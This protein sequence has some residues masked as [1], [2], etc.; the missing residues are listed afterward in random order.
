MRRGYRVGVA[1]AIWKCLRDHN[2][3]QSRSRSSYYRAKKSRMEKTWPFRT[4]IIIAERLRST[5]RTLPAAFAQAPLLGLAARAAA[6]LPVSHANISLDFK[7]KK[8]LEGLGYPDEVRNYVWLGAFRPDELPSLLGRHVDEA[9]LFAPVAAV[10]REAP[11]ESHLERV[12]YQDVVLYLAH[13]ILVKVD[14]ASMACSL[15]VRAPFL[16]TAFA[17]YVA[18]LPLAHKLDRFDGKAM[19]KRAVAPWLPS[20]VVNRPK[21]GFGMPIGPWLRG[22][23]AGFLRETLLDADGLAGTGMVA[24]AEVQRLVDEHLRGA[25]DHRKRLWSLMVLELWRRHHLGGAAC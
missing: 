18:G 24:R 15:E 1:W 22:P 8:T 3:I 5:R 11:G 9:E 20:K 25:V 12:L 19:L 4:A 13:Q 21:K 16:D 6:K 17:E 10:Y 2:V 7:I 14:R 23:L